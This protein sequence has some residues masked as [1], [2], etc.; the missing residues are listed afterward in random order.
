MTIGESAA[1]VAPGL[2]DILAHPQTLGDLVP[3]EQFF[4]SLENVQQLG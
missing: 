4:G 2:D 3:T 1:A